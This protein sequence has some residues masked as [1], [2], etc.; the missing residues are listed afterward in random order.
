MSHPVPTTEIKYPEDGVTNYPMRGT[1]PDIIVHD[2]VDVCP[3]CNGTG[4]I[5]DFILLRDSNKWVQDGTRPCQCQEKEV[6]EY[7]MGTG[8]V[9]EDEYDREGQL[10]GV[11][12]IGPKKCI[13]KLDID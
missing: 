12:T 3:D 7:C 13:C 8:E 10:I 9:F 5:P 6:C 2:E 11:R 4:L 1:Q